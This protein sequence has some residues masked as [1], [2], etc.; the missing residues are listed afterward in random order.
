MSNGDGIKKFDTLFYIAAALSI[1]V[2]AVLGWWIYQQ[3]LHIARLKGMSLHTAAVHYPELIP[4]IVALGRNVNELDVDHNTALQQA[5]VFRKVES[6][7]ALLDAGANPNNVGNNTINPTA[8]LEA[9][10]I[11][12]HPESVEITKMLLEGGADPD[13][14]GAHGHTSL[15]RAARIDNRAVAY[16]ITKA[17]LDA[18]ADVNIEGDLGETALQHA[19]ASGNAAIADLLL[20]A[21][22]D[23]EQRN[24]NGFRAIDQLNA[25]SQ[26]N[27]IKIQ[28]A[29]KRHGFDHER[30]PELF[31]Q[32]RVEK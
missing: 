16:E 25:T 6:I 2:I 29:F 14:T 8:L 28:D 11:P 26:K 27:Q 23:P 31:K 19:V 17:L 1:G 5:V 22:A 4:E 24:K 32:Y 12:I 21:G 3:Q 15:I 10:F 13:A 30:R 9:T 20:T 7:K 18:G